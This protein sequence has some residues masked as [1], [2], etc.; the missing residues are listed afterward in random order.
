MTK[1][2]LRPSISKL[3]KNWYSEQEIS[4]MKKAAFDKGFEHFNEASFKEFGEILNRVQ[5]IATE[6]FHLAIKKCD[7]S[8]NQIR[9]K[10]VSIK[11]FE[12]VFIMAENDFLSKDTY[13]NVFEIGVDFLDSIQDDIC[14]TFLYMPLSGVLN[15]SEFALN[16]FSFTYDPNRTSKS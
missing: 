1:T 15:E 7:I 14:I 3:D 11:S 2:I 6:F 9:L 12:L 5:D 8:F 13:K 4:L 16:G 10:P